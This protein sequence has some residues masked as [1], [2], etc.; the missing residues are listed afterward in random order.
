MEFIDIDL[1]R[2]EKRNRKKKKMGTFV[3]TFIYLFFGVQDYHKFSL[4]VMLSFILSHSFFLDRM[5]IKITF[6]N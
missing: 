3:F 2:E 4:E 5:K 6:K 1:A